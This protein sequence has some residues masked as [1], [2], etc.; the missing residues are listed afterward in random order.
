MAKITYDNYEEDSWDSWESTLSRGTG[1]IPEQDHNAYMP[2]P[3]E[4]ERRKSMLRWL[5]DSGF[6]RR[7]ICAVMVDEQFKI[8]D[9]KTLVDECGVPETIRRLDLFLLEAECDGNK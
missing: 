5:Q 7:V 4:L 8:D 9:V 6:P 1:K 2:S 3:S